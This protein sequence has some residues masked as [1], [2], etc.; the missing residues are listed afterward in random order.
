M[1]R[2]QDFFFLPLAFVLSAACGSQST[3]TPAAPPISDAAAETDADPD[4]TGDAPGQGGADADATQDAMAPDGAV[5][6][7]FLQGGWYRENE[8]A[9][10][11][12]A[13]V[14]VQQ[15]IR[16]DGTGYVVITDGPQAYCGESG[17]FSL[18]APGSIHFQPTGKEGSPKPSSCP[19]ALARDESVSTD[20]GSLVIGTAGA[21]SRYAR[22]RDVPKLFLPFETH[23]GD[24]ADDGTLPGSTVIEK[25][26]SICA[27]SVAKPDNGTYRALL[28]DGANRAAVPAKDWVLQPITTYYRSDG[29]LDLFTTTDHAVA[30]TDTFGALAASDLVTSAWTGL[31]FDFLGQNTCNGWSSNS[32]TAIGAS[33]YPGQGEYL[34]A[35]G[36]PSS[37]A[38][39]SGFV[40]VGTGTP[41]E[42]I[43][44][45]AEPGLLGS[46]TASATAQVNN[47]VAYR[48][49]KFEGNQY[50]FT[51]HTPSSYC[52][53]MGFY[54][55]ANGALLFQP[56]RINGFGS[57]V[58]DTG[59]TE[60]IVIGIDELK[61]T[62]V[63]VTS[64]YQRAPMVAKVF[65]TPETHNGGLATDDLLPGANAIEKADAFC[66]RSIGRPDGQN[67][68]AV[69]VDG[70][71]RSAAPLTDWPLR[72][73]TTYYQDDGLRTVWVTDSSGLFNPL[74][75]SVVVLEGATRIEYLW[76][77]LKG[78]FTV[79]ETCQGWTSTDEQQTGGAA[80]IRSATTSAVGAPCA[81]L[82]IGL[83]CASE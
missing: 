45:T 44:L 43:S 25:A 48:R 41:I 39:P 16:F 75:G 55:V 65:I 22:I 82:T 33:A 52:A 42:P 17:T 19:D 70:V 9:S 63:G 26:D 50:T 83:I 57:C 31:G 77:G 79:G 62:R 54:S 68:R 76:S 8:G 74:G 78:D 30:D 29:A 11:V 59:H 61:L 66:Q 7:A 37:C 53:E 49:F 34:F 21:A 40:C 12:D 5:T 28:V 73:F 10:G 13:N 2:T 36:G 69:L 38:T 56:V 14:A 71:N 47:E 27:G 80:D 18:S 32:S 64:H 35:F 4:A 81:S 46:W 72:P 23:D 51:W 24:L 58:I 3:T 15:R 20:S 6:T 67:Y 60:D 1:F